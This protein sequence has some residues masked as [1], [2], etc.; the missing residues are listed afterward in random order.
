VQLEVLDKLEKFNDL[1]R[2]QTHYLPAC[3]LVP[4]L[5]RLPHALQQ[6]NPLLFIDPMKYSSLSHRTWTFCGRIFLVPFPI[7]YNIQMYQPRSAASC[8]FCNMLGI[9]SVD[10]ISYTTMKTSTNTCKISKLRASPP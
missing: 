5:S 9:Y 1:T 10:L 6:R 7:A 3:S 8:N 2:T 4:P